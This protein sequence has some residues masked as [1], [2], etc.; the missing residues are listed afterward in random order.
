MPS[1]R[2]I[3]GFRC[4]VLA[5]GEVNRRDLPWRATKDPWHVLVS[6]VM[7]Q[8][9]QVA[10]VVDPYRRFI[11]RFPTPAACAAAGAPAVVRAWAGLGYNRRATNLYRTA[12]LVVERHRGRLPDD[13]M[14]LLTLPGVGSYT[15]RAVLTFAFG[16]DVGIVDTNVGRV[17]ARAV[18]GTPLRAREA[19]SLAD[20]L[21]PPGDSWAYNQALFDLGTGHCTARRPDCASCPIRGRC[22]WASTQLPDPAPASAGTARRQTTFEGS[23]RQGRGRMVAALR[24]RRLASGELADAAGWPDQAGRARRVAD[25]L[26]AEGMARWTLAGDLRLA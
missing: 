26:V 10:R 11:E 5:W 25:A 13:L 17:L 1:A 24:Q 18:A 9:T 7:L 8:Q 2:W 15:A 19:Q 16:Q 20:R 4:D 23:D 3:E 21:V 12:V 6:E 14:L 22:R